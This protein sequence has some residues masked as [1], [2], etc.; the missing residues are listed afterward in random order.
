MTHIFNF[1]FEYMYCNLNVTKMHRFT[2][3]RACY[4]CYPKRTTSYNHVL[5]LH[6]YMNY[7]I[8]RSVL[9]GAVIAR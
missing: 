4:K 8:T 6:E 9:W 2:L 5:S 7:I 3:L 1:F